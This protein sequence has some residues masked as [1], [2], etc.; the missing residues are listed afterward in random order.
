MTR[1]VVVMTH[2]VQYLSPLYRQ[3]AQ[4]IDL[5]VVYAVEPAPSR[6]GIGFG[7]PVTWDVPL[8]EGYDA[9]VLDRG[10]NAPVGAGEF[11]LDAPEMGETLS[12]LRPDVLLVNGWHARVLLRAIGWAR[13]RRLP[14]IY[15]GENWW[16]DDL[17]PVRRAL[18]AA[19]NAAALRLFT[20]WIAI[21]TNARAY[22]ERLGLARE[23]I[24]DSPYAVDNQRFAAAAAG[25]SPADAR[26]AL[27]LGDG[28]VVLFS[29]KLTPIKRPQDLVRAAAHLRGVELLFAGAGE[30]DAAC[31]QLAAQL[32]VR[33]V[34]AGFQNQRELPRVYAAADCLVLPSARETWGLVVNEALACG[35]PC[36]VSDGVGCAPDLIGPATGATFPVGDSAALAAAIERTLAAA[37]PEACRAAAA[38]SSLEAAA[39]GI[40]QACQA[41]VGS[42]PHAGP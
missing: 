38:G 23:R 28:R 18:W 12:A 14:V 5:S 22:L 7:V 13:T 6:Q 42:G 10:G 31:R 34:F 37:S 11:A 35:V 24:F 9:H 39:R 33:A 19:K 30:E 21:G 41:A 15:R 27:G 25:I 8:L 26:R 4:E 32:G 29:G 20:H 17:Q 40:V 3:L 36:V 16:R 1:L 2:P